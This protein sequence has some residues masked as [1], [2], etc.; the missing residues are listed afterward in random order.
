MNNTRITI[1]KQYLEDEPNEPFNLYAIAT[2]Y[3]HEEP[4]TAMEYFEQLLEKHPDYLGTY[5]HAG[6]LYYDFN[7]VEKAKL[8]LGKGIELA[9]QQKQNKALGE[10]HNALNEILDDLDSE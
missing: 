9:L 2:E 5:Y 8:V 6:K 10:L 3:I 1:L 7:Q 4:H